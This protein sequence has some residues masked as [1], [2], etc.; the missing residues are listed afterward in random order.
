MSEDRLQS[1]HIQQ[2]KSRKR[3]VQFQ[4]LKQE[5]DFENCCPHCYALFLKSEKKSERRYCCQNGAYLDDDEEE[6]EEDEENENIRR[7]PNFHNLPPVIYEYLRD[8]DAYK[9]VSVPHGNDLNIGGDESST[10]ASVDSERSEDGK[11]DVKN[12][13]GIS[14]NVYNNILSLGKI[15]M[16]VFIFW[17]L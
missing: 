16:F 1:K 11:I 6:D 5:W 4:S 2:K 13:L 12:T 8:N 3:S 15:V 7:F 14:S 9:M 10:N 17:K